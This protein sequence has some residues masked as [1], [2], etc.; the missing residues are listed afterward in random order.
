[1]FLAGETLVQRCHVGIWAAFTATVSE[2]V[3]DGNCNPNG[4][5]YHSSS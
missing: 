5:D 4:A 3:V 2:V 1:M